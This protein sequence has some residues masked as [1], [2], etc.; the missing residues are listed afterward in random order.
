METTLS[1]GLAVA[2]LVAVYFAWRAK[3]E[4]RAADVAG[5]RADGLAAANAAQVA[6]WKAAEKSRNLALAEE[7]ARQ[8]AKA[9]GVTNAK[10]AAQW[11]RVAGHTHPEKVPGD[12]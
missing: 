8:L 4:G 6:A 1:L 5:F 9:K 10:E 11:L 3:V 12:E 7:W 2:V